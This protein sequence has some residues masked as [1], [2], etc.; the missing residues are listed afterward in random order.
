M[1]EAH[2]LIMRAVRFYDYGEQRIER[3]D[4]QL[5]SLLG[6]PVTQRTTE[7]GVITTRIHDSLALLA[8]LGWRNELGSKG[9]AGYHAAC[10]YREQITTAEVR[11]AGWILARDTHHLFI[12]FGVIRK[13]TCSP[14]LILSMMGPYMCLAGAIFADEIIVQPFTDYIYLGGDPDYGDRVIYIARIFKAA[15]NA[16]CDLRHYYERS[17]TQEGTC[18]P[19][20]PQPSFMANSDP[21][22][23]L[24][25]FDR[26]F[27]HNPASTL[28]VAKMGRRDV[29]VKFTSQYCSGAHRL[30]AKHGL[31]PELHFCGRI[32]G[33]L[34]MVVMDY[35]PGDKGDVFYILTGF[36]SDILS[37]IQ[38]ALE[39]LHGEDYVFGDLRPQNMIIIR[40]VEV[41]MEKYAAQHHQNGVSDDALRPDAVTSCTMMN[42]NYDNQRF[43]AVLIDFDWCGKDSEARYP[44]TLNDT[45]DIGWAPGVERFGL[46]KK[47]HDEYLLRKLFQEPW[48]NGY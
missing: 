2:K 46:M 15:K 26:L 21:C 16:L 43:G 27:P 23:I 5:E 31:A 14:A 37:N 42:D 25:Y 19:H 11:P 6:F 12:Q 20:L 39:L 38:K 8:C 33:G 9:D 44:S 17:L 32:R 48:A 40:K 1:R 7:S 35:V 28:F 18:G 30:L 4:P 41:E 13:R 34:W 24:L 45:G 3:M 10:S 22:P 29:V 36:T 47:E